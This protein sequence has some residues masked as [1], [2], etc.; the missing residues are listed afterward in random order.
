[1]MAL[2]QGFF[3]ACNEVGKVRGQQERQ[4]ERGREEEKTRM[5]N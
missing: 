5:K 4:G 2:V 1:M 3:V